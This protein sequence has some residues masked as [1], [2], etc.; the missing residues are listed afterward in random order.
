MRVGI[1][2]AGLQ[3]NR[4]AQGLLG[5]RDTELLIVTAKE[6]E[7]AK[8]LA[9]RMRCDAG[10]GWEEVVRRPDI[11]VIVICTPPDIHARIALVHWKKVQSRSNVE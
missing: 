9:A 7:D 1:I 2:G 6:L 4:R 8:P 11:D 5:L 10:E 3:G